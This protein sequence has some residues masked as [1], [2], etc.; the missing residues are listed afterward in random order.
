MTKRE[1]GDL[2]YTIG[3]SAVVLTFITFMIFIR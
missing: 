1:Y 3:A 2:A